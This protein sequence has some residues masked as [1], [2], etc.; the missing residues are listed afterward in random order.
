MIDSRQS[1]AAKQFAADWA[2]KGY[3]KGQSQV[4]GSPF[5]KGSMAF[6]NPTNSS[7]LKI[8]SCLTIRLLL[9]ASLPLPMY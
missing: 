1:S 2:G 8:R 3:E 9:M 7:P 5:C 4:F 6:L